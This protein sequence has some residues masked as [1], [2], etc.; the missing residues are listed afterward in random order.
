MTTAT[1]ITAHG[2]TGHLD[3]GLAMRELQCVLGIAAGHSTKELA[4]D[5]G[6][7]PDSIK[8]RVLSATT[9]LGVIRRAQLVSEAIKRGLISPAAALA[10]LLAAHGAL[11]DDPMAR[12]RRGSSE[13]KIEYRVAVRRAEAAL[14]A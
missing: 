6:V 3:R 8:K 5:L 10:I 14:T 7:Q 9:K 4:K 13:K 12:V 2:W 11:A 1:S